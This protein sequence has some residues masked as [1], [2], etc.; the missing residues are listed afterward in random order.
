MSQIWSIY[1]YFIYKCHICEHGDIIFCITIY[2][3]IYILKR[4]IDSTILCIIHKLYRF[5]KFL[6]IK[7]FYGGISCPY[8]SFVY[9]VV[10]IEVGMPNDRTIKGN[11]CETI[12]VRG[13]SIKISRYIYL[14]TIFC[15]LISNIMYSWKLIDD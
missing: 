12:Q 4:I 11:E 2:L 5:G 7:I 1:K 8:Y 14:C 3:H 15:Y 13:V 10:Q 6:F 9:S